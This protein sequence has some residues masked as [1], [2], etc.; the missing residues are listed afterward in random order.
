LSKNV[1]RD[2]DLAAYLQANV[3]PQEPR[4]PSDSLAYRAWRRRFML[5]RLHLGLSIAIVAYFTFILL[6][7]IQGFIDPSQLDLTWMAMAATA[8]LGLVTCFIVHRTAAGQQHPEIIFL[9]ASWSITIIE[10]IWAT[11]RGIAFPGLFS[12]TLVF[13]TQST[14]IP[15]N[16]PLH[17]VSQL[18]VLI[19]FFGV[20]TVLDLRPQGAPLWDARQDLYLFWFC[21]ICNVSVYLYEQLQKSEFKARLQ[22]EAEQ[23]KSERLLLNILPEAIA[24]KLKQDQR[25]IADS[26]AEAT[27]LFADI[28]GFTQLSADVPP[29]EVVNLLNRIF[30]A[31]DQLVEHH[32]LEKIKTI[33]DAYMVVGGLPIERVD[34]VEAIANLAL[35]MQHVMIQF[36]THDN[37]PLQIRIGINSG[38]VIAGVI[39]RKKFI[40]DLW[41]NAVNIASR[42]ESQG[43]AGCI[44][45]TPIV[46]ERLGDRYQF[47]D[48]GVVDIKGK[49]R[50]NTYLL[51]GRKE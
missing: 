30:S 48:R 19:Y 22:L 40:Y 44:Q 35:D 4:H 12:W 34:H 21:C 9:A 29:Q 20:N 38:P 28:V 42:M 15:V 46:Y 25:T 18:G 16:W 41:G 23:E 5:Q 17:L 26:F 50:M 49:G 14:L 47:Q 43:L 11:V 51:M 45:V 33:G 8:E 3:D 1:T 36:K 2:S 13:L 27:V 24:Q 31:F 37:Q 7:V 32:G 39:G 6:R 10:Q